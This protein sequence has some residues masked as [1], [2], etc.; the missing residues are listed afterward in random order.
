M[1]WFYVSFASKAAGHLGSTVVEADTSKSALAVATMRGL[2]PGGE[3]MIVAIHLAREHFPD[4]V[5]L[6]NRLASKAEP[7][8]MGAISGGRRDDA[9]YACE[10]CNAGRPHT[11]HRRPS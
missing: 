9:D 1:T 6:R 7:V 8:A 2:N 11:H 4:R 5:A 3:A 10:D